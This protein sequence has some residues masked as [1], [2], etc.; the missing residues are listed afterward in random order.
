MGNSLQPIGIR[1]VAVNQEEATLMNEMEKVVLLN[2]IMDEILG[3]TQ[4]LVKTAD[5]PMIDGSLLA[6]ARELE[7]QINELARVV[8]GVRRLSELGAGQLALL[9][10]A[11]ELYRHQIRTLGDDIRTQLDRVIHTLTQQSGIRA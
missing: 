6:R 4:D 8:R 10:T 2:E 9:I 7:G 11:L 5:N 3:A 1:W